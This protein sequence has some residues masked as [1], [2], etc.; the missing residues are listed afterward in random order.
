MLYTG[1]FF[2]LISLFSL[3]WDLGRSKSLPFPP[4]S[5]SQNLIIRILTQVQS[6]L[7]AHNSKGT[8]QIVIQIIDKSKWHPLFTTLVC[9]TVTVKL[10]IYDGPLWLWY[11][12][13]SDHPQVSG[14]EKCCESRHL[15]GSFSKIPGPRSNLGTSWLHEWYMCDLAALLL[16]GW[17]E[18]WAS[19]FGSSPAFRNHVLQPSPY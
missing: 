3:Y 5:S 15:Y 18:F 9:V 6:S 8:I 4:L 13:T 2:V 12:P 10:I 7:L 14:C 17:I 11:H 19:V 1:L 16:D